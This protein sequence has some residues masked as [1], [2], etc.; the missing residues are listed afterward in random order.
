MLIKWGIHPL[1][2]IQ[3]NIY[4]HTHIK[5]RFINLEVEDGYMILLGNA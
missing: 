3:A 4:V 5:C 2:N 1:V